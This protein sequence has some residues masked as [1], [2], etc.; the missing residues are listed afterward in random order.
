MKNSTVVTALAALVLFLLATLVLQG[1]AGR[2][3]RHDICRGQNATLGV[4]HDLIALSTTPPAGRKL[5]AAQ[6]R[7]IT[8]FQT[9]AY[10]RID[11]ARC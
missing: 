11:S 10:A 4:L 9:K 2:A 3:R 7:A 6:V 1:F 5:S 8:E